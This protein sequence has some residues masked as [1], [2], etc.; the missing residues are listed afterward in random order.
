MDEKRGELEF[1]K[2]AFHEFRKVMFIKD[3][4]AK[5]AFVTRVCEEYL[6]VDK[7]GSILGR[8]E[9]EV[10]KDSAL[11]ERYYQEDLQIL[12]TGKGLRT[13]DKVDTDDGPVYIE[14]VREAIRS[15]DGEIVGISGVVN[16]VTELVSYK[17]KFEQLSLYDSLTQAYSRH[18]TAKYNFDN[19][20]Y[21]PCSYIMCDCNDLKQVND[22]MGHAKG[23]QYICMAAQVLR[24]AAEPESVLVR[25][26]GDEFLLITPNCDEAGHLRMLERIEQE[27]CK[28]RQCQLHVEVAVGGAVRRSV[29]IGEQA[30]IQQ[31][32]RNMYLDKRKRKGI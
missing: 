20:K 28:L 8:T 7:W 22:Q 13:L 6:S 2:H 31:A 10:Q 17:K 1:V 16:D 29:E 21:L 26:G 4:Q 5:Y 11:G 15:G 24:K 12:A 19:P 9:Q 18:Y 25:W 14:V 3:T 30:V 32:D 27:Q 23:D